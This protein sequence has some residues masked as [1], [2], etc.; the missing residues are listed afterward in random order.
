MPKLSPKRAPNNSVNVSILRVICSDCG[1]AV[2]DETFERLETETEIT[3]H[4]SACGNP[5][6][7]SL[8]SLVSLTPANFEYRRVL[9][10]LDK[11]L[12]GLGLRDL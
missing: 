2:P 7:I 1:Q 8:W 4:C 10:A 3:H 6:V 5:I 9:T 11:I 12:S